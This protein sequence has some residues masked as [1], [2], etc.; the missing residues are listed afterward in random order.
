MKN[1]LPYETAYLEVVAYAVSWVK[2][3]IDRVQRGF[4][5]N[6]VRLVKAILLM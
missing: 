1:E 4:E 6:Y 2:I 5:L 3:I